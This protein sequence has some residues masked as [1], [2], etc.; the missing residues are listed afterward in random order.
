MVDGEFADGTA[1]CLYYPDGHERVG[2]FKGMGVQPRQHEA[3]PHDGVLKLVETHLQDPPPPTDWRFQWLA[4][5]PS[6]HF[7]ISALLALQV[8]IYIFSWG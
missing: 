1:Q 2:Y 7:K 8:S 3:D 4:R 5:L 6:F